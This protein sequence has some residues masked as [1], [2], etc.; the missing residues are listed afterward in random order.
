[1]FERL[2]H[3]LRRLRRDE[4]G[5]VTVEFVMIMPL[6]FWGY[7]A[8]YVFFDAYRQD[9]INLK[10]AY[11]V[12]DLVSRETQAINDQ[13]ID[14]MYQLTRILT[15]TN[16]PMSMRISVVRWDADDEE[17]TLD[18]SSARG[19]ID[20]LTDANL[21]SLTDRLPTM[22]DEERVILVETWNTWSPPFTVGMEVMSIDNFVF[23]RPRFAPQVVWES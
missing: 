13:Y 8:S 15:R 12:G 11:T 21:T 16:S 3:L 2:Q 20:A 14:S 7:G 18:W 9:T 22:P 17:Y 1:M 10:A 19:G 23:T 4:R 5:S 6:L